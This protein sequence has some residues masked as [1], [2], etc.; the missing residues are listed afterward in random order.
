MSRSWTSVACLV[1][2]LT[3]VLVSI[4]ARAQPSEW[5]DPVYLETDNVEDGYSPMIATDSLG[6]AIVVWTANGTVWANRYLS[7]LG[8]A[9][10]ESISNNPPETPSLD[11]GI[12]MNSS[13]SAIA[14]WEQFEGGEF[15]S[16]WS[17]QFEPD[18]GWALPETIMVLSPSQTYPKVAVDEQGDALL[19]WQKYS[20]TT[21]HLSSAWRDHG[22]SGWHLPELVEQDE[23]NS[24]FGFDVAIGHA[25]EAVVAWKIDDGIDVNLWANVRSPLTGWAQEEVISQ[26]PFVE[27]GSPIVSIDPEGDATALWTEYTPPHYRI[28]S[29]RH[30]S[31]SGWT[32]AERVDL[33]DSNQSLG[34]FESGGSFDLAIWGRYDSAQQNV[35]VSRYLPGQGWET[36]EVLATNGTSFLGDNQVSVNSNGD[37]FASWSEWNG[38]GWTIWSRWFNVTTGWGPPEQVTT[39]TL[40]DVETAL[41]YS[42]DA[43]MTWMEYDAIINIMASHATVSE[44]TVVP[45]FGQLAI[46]AIGSLV[47]IVLASGLTTRGRGPKS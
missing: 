30:I 27:S 29:N 25:G 34:D 38:T 22:D 1:L 18:I 46:P 23:A 26:S 45:E 6:N 36:P 14:V 15:F 16:I 17:A 43:F 10:A 13:G 5:G 11:A 40:S 9:G 39:G 3:M 41:S 19:V 44:P 21:F 7:G 12:A 28:W 37:A 20:G 24:S 2:S 31:G 42:G 8:W 32:G 4:D 35:T 47:A 33:D